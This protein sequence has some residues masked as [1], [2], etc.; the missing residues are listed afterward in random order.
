MN[1]TEN[2]VCPHCSRSDSVKQLPPNSLQPHT[3]RFGCGGCGSVWTGVRT[4]VQALA[5]RTQERM[6]A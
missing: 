3:P 5:R 6:C 4:H 1:A 2:G